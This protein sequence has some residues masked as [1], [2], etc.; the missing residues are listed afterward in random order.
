MLSALL[1]YLCSTN[2]EGGSV[3]A[4]MDYLMHP[5]FKAFS[6]G[7]ISNNVFE[8]SNIRFQLE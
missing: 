8:I 2:D 7:V 1:C 4:L 6:M 3:I 5:I